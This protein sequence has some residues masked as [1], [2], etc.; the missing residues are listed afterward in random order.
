MKKFFRNSRPMDL[1]AR[2]GVSFAIRLMWD[3]KA[4]SDLGSEFVVKQ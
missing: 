1:G 2:L 3:E 4:F